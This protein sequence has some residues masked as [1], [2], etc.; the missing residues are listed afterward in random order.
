MDSIKI[1][2]G[3]KRIAINDDPGRVIV[4]NPTDVLFAEKFYSLIGEFQTRLTEYEK[5]SEEIDQVQ[6][7]DGNGLPA[8]LDQRLALMREAC[9][10]MRERIDYLFGAGTSHK[11]FGDTLELDVFQQFFEGITPFVKEAR[12]EKIA[13]Y[14]VKK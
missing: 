13:Q 11:A 2:T 5:R 1:T 8:N 10:Y 9:E 14:K 4:F 6:D 12:T 3:E 7:V